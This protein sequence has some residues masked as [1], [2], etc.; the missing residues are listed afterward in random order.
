M[1]K[2]HDATIPPENKTEAAT[3]NVKQ[4]NH[5]IQKAKKAAETNGCYQDS[6]I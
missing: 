1:S 2:T 6:I 4:L 3:L 5:L